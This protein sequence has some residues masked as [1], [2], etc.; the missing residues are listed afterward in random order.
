MINFPY[1]NMQQINLDWLL[2]TVQELKET[3]VPLVKLPAV[4]DDSDDG[5]FALLSKYVDSIPQGVSFIQSR[6]DNEYCQIYIMFF[7]FDENNGFGFV[8]PGVYDNITLSQV[9][10]YDGVWTS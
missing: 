1:F 4:S 7:R 3:R 2:Q 8:M 6:E 10:L 5:L 9:I